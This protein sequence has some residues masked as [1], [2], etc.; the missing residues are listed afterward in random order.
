MQ[1]YKKWS[2]QQLRALLLL[3]ISP[4]PASEQKGL[5]HLLKH[6]LENRLVVIAL[7]CLG[8]LTTVSE[9]GTLGILIIAV[10]SLI[11]D[12]P[13]TTGLDYVDSIIKS[14]QANSEM[15]FFYLALVIAI[16]LQAFKGIT[17]YLG[18]ALAIK[19]KV[20]IS[21]KLQASIIS[22]QLDLTY[23]E[24]AKHSTGY[25]MTLLNQSD[26]FSGLAIVGF[27]F[28]VSVLMLIGYLLLLLFTAPIAGLVVIAFSIVLSIVLIKV[29]SKLRSLGNQLAEAAPHADKVTVDYFRSPKLI[30]I[31]NSLDSVRH[32]IISSRRRMLNISRKSALINAAITPS[33]DFTIL[34]GAAAFLLLTLFLSQSGYADFGATNLIQLFILYRT[35]PYVKQINKF[36]MTLA[37]A[38]PV[39]SLV[40]SYL[41]PSQINLIRK[42][43]RP[44][45]PLKT[46]IQL[47]DVYYRYPGTKE[48]AVSD[49]NLSIP[50]HTHVAL[51]GRSGSGKSTI[52][53]LIISLIEPTNGTVLV[54]NCNR[55][56][57][58][59]S[60][61]LSKIGVVDQDVQLLNTTVYENISFGS[62]ELS[63]EQVREAAK[64]SKADEFI[65]QL[66]QAYETRVGESGYRLSMGQRQRIVLA[67]ALSCSPELLIFDEATSALDSLSESEIKKAIS[68]LRGEVTMVT[69]AHRF[70]TI[71]DVD[72]IYVLENGRIKEH[73]SLERLI[74]NEDLFYSLWKEQHLLEHS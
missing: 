5:R 68:S 18:T 23:Q 57:L 24:A 48:F 14:I 10:N 34:L 46:G 69:I 58:L 15:L 51:V 64:L 13:V 7:I 31:T 11:N 27:G 60:D 8:L 74:Q 62:N 35:M 72:H 16:L 28:V 66:P 45:P 71:Q 42:T 55:N 1:S 56:E 29:V 25:L 38:L 39:A 4:M 40:S 32:R 36:R 67:R 3:I 26:G 44:I 12:S 9:I 30:R 22:R 53:D 41:S 65:R 70:S 59:L 17:H 43:G 19:L 37:N 47:S 21:L 6:I 52:A 54:D 33:V 50:K 73:G 2:R 20:S 49:I 63:D 61:W